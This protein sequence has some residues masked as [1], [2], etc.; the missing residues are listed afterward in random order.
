MKKLVVSICAAAALAAATT[1]PCLA[2]DSPWNGTWK[3]NQSRSQL[4]GDT[5]TLSDLG[6]GRI[7][8]TNGATMDFDFA[9]DGKDYTT[10]G[11]QS[12]ACTRAS[13]TTEDMVLKDKGVVISKTHRD[14]S[15]DGKTLTSTTSGT[16][17]DGTAY[18]Y[19]TVS[20]HLSS[21]PGMMGKWK[22]V[23]SENSASDVMVIKVT[24]P[25]AIHWEIPGYKESI[26]G[27]MDGTPIAVVG[28]R[29]TDGL[30]IS[31]KMAGPS[32]LTYELKLKDK[33]MNEGEQ[34]LSA[35][36][37]TLT[38]TSWVPGKPNEKEIEVYEK[39]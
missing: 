7:H 30:S 36:G 29:A 20:T 13:D 39:Q 38:D 35:D 4:T 37:K 10:I 1:A 18:T 32:R 21:E 19:T 33:T 26:D 16:Q 31:F 5:F 34:V 3:L 6:D 15:A 14:L 9:C 8:Y 28:P 12:M 11:D 22:R 23:K 24:P 25:D 2:A 27:K 17:P